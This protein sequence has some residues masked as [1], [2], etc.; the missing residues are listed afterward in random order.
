[1]PHGGRW[2]WQSGIFDLAGEVGGIFQVEHRT[3]G[4]PYVLCGQNGVSKL[5]RIESGGIGIGF[6][7][8]AGPGQVGKVEPAK[9]FGG[10]LVFCKLAIQFVAVTPRGRYHHASHG[11]VNVGPDSRG[12][13]SVR[14]FEPPQGSQDQYMFEIEPSARRGF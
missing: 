14:V 9:V 2:P 10:L 5:M 13:N 6:F 1:M 4:A 12:H 7:P 8:L 11:R 3:T